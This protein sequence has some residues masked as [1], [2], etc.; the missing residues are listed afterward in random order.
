M[1]KRKNAAPGTG[2]RHS[3]G[4]KRK[5]TLTA[6]WVK[7]QTAYPADTKQLRERQIN[8]SAIFTWDITLVLGQTS[9]PHNS[10]PYTI[11]L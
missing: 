3:T 2:T 4:W 8:A 1:I 7:P 6:S 5:K 9:L 10:A 11:G